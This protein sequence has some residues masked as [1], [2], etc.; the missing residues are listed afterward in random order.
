MSSCGNLASLAFLNKLLALDE[1]RFVKME[2]LDGDLTPLL[3]LKSV[4]FI[5]KRSYSH[6]CA[7]VEAITAQHS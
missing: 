3:R 1:F 5:D 6:T 4:G 2:V 7:E